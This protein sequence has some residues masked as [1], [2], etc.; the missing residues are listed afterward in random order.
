MLSLGYWLFIQLFLKAFEMFCTISVFSLIHQEFTET[1]RFSMELCGQTWLIG[2]LP[3]VWFFCIQSLKAKSTI[4]AHRLGR[5]W[6]NHKNIQWWNLVADFYFT[7]TCF[8]C[9]RPLILWFESIRT[10]I[11]SFGFYI[12]VPKKLLGGNIFCTINKCSSLF[13]PEVIVC[14]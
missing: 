14:V 8:C 13:P 6:A 4:I 3:H 9:R 2:P 7:I 12:Y 10:N 5:F 11:I 1:L